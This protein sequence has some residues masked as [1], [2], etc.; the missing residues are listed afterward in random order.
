MSFQF[1]T[2]SSLNALLC[3]LHTL[4]AHKVICVSTLGLLVVYSSNIR[5]SNSSMPKLCRQHGGFIICTPRQRQQQ[6]QLTNY[7]DFSRATAI[8]YS[9]LLCS[10]AVGSIKPQ[11]CIRISPLLTTTFSHIASAECQKTNNSNNCH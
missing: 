9:L 11:K 10:A 5:E 4:F 6:L 8:F 7:T 1:E 3:V 2:L